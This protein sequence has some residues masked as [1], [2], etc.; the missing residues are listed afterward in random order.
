MAPTCTQLLTKIKLWM[1]FKFVS[2]EGWILLRDL[3][4]ILLQG[5][6]LY[7]AVCFWYLVKSA[8]SSVNGQVTL[9]NVPEK[10]SHVIFNYYSLSGRVIFNKRIILL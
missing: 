5:N 3:F 4:I 9:Y 6:Q 2:V 8:L 10:Q 1:I 7:M